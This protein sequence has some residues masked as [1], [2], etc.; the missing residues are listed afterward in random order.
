ML[1][2]FRE[3]KKLD[4]KKIT[5]EIFQYWKKNKIILRSFRNLY[6][7][8][9]RK[10]VLYEGPPSL[11][12]EPG[13]HHMLSRTIKDIF[14]RFHALKGNNVFRKAGWDTHG[15]P[16]E[17]AIEKKI[18]INKNHIGKK[19][20][21][22]KYND[23][24]YKFVKQSLKKWISFTEKIGYWIDTENAYITCNAKYIESVWSLIK[25]LHDKNFLYKGYTVQ[26]YSPSAGTGISYNELN[27]QGAYRKVIQP[28]PFLKFKSIKKSL[29][30]KFKNIKEDIY[31]V[32]WTTTPWTLPSNTA[33]AVGNNIYYVLIKTYNKNTHKKELLI[34]SKQSI[35]HVL[36]SKK[37][38][39]VFKENELDLCYDGKIPFLIINEFKGKELFNS[40]Y[41]QLLPWF[42]PYYNK[43]HAFKIVNGDFIKE[44]E[45]TG[46]V[47]IAPTF[48][49][50]DF[51]LSK[52]YNIPLMLVLNEKNQPIPLVD[53]QGRF[54]NIL[55]FGFGGKYIKNE[56]DPYGIQKTSVDDEMISFLKKNNCILRTEMYSHFYPY[57]WRTEKPI[58]YYPL[59]SWFL[60]TTKIKEKIIL[61]NKT[62]KWHPSFIGNKR[63]HSWLQNLKDWNLSR[64]RYWGT[65]IP[66]WTTQEGD[67]K[68]V[69][70]SIK[71]LY[72][73]IQKSID[74]GFM[75]INIFKD[76]ILDDMSNENYENINLHKH[77]VDKIILVSSKGKPMKRESDVI[78]VWFDSGSMPYAQIHY[79]FENKEMIDNKLLFPCDFISEG[80]DQTR[81]WF[82]TL[83]TISSMVFDTIAYK[84]VVCTGLVLDKYGQKMSK[85]KGNSINPFDLLEKYGPDAIRWYIVY[86]SPQW[87]N[88][89][90]NLDGIDS[91]IK[92]FFVTWFNVYKFFSLYANIDGFSHKKE[93]QI[94]LKDCTILDLWILSELNTM[95]KKTNESY[96]IFNP[97][98]SARLIFYFVLNQLSNWYVRLCRRRF[99]KEE[100]SKNKE[101][102]YRILYYCLINISKISSPIIPFFSE[103]M[104]V[105][106]RIPYEEKELISVHLSDFPKYDNQFIN[107]RLEKNM[108]FIQQ[109]VGMIFSLRKKNNIKIKQPIKKGLIFIY[110]PNHL[111][112]KKE[113]NELEGIL[114]KESNVKK[115]DFI[116]NFQ[117]LEMEKNIKPNYKV[118]GPKFRNKTNKIS[119]I[120]NQFT[121]KEI[122]KIE[123]NQSIFIPLEGEKISISLED[124]IIISTPYK[125]WSILKGK[126]MT[127]ALDLRIS[128]HLEEEGFIREFIRNIQILRKQNN[129]HVVD[130]IVLFVQVKDFTY[131]SFIKQNQP[132]ICK[133]I[134]AKKILFDFQKDMKKISMNNH[135][136]YIK[137]NKLKS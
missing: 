133:E 69:I 75:K 99:W 87:E 86:N 71:Q 73:E 45:G 112:K 74:K 47:H 29:P 64:S 20:S 127:V 70:G 5:E 117:K 55:P 9:C 44:K 119:K 32:S 115:I 83:H 30:E 35:H 54:L 37:Y 56:Y 98:Q 38:Y 105:D 100:Y 52:Q 101:C 109:I 67:E 95:I 21:I 31:L 40:K 96:K 104:Y 42:L 116:T 18:G 13:V 12:G 126:N 7:K 131:K 124:V 51:S 57:C 137:I 118:L 107:K 82:F 43:D 136:F 25:K 4:I 79:P 23:L 11:N 111:P 41:E 39:E 78:D 10:Y 88:L 22:K 108:L 128:H 3:Y 26:P 92:K 16:V 102:A 77:I 93:K 76:F 132:L 114:L 72:S 59:N 19:I 89:K 48:G 24:C 62:I 91:S 1:K 15:L 28:S 53:L 66:I 129:Y 134:L 2:K 80:I 27:M 46:I 90:F 103:R 6:Q 113:L 120:I 110:N 36:I 130:R 84:N 14:C 17:I 135:I 121:Q 58:F 125:N 34:L 49:M 68:K 123:K 122:E 61:L 106:L 65:P 94:I 63:F 50:D 8:K 60:S 33:L 85:S 97:H 81:G